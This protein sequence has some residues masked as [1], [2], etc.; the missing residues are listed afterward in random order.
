MKKRLL[1]GLA[2]GAAA[3]LGLGACASTPAEP[4]PTTTDGAANA[5]QT[6]LT[7]GVFNGWP[8]GEA[9]SY[10]WKIVLEEQGYDVTLEYA[11]AG[12]V[13]LGLS[14]GDYDVAL[15]GWFPLTHQHYLE[16]YPDIV[17]L[18][19]WNDDAVLTIHGGT[20]RT[21]RI[22]VREHRPH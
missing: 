21:D 2:I 4:E 7:I 11:D 16:E 12:T 3:A 14:E 22:A 18:G 1:A 20:S 9:A 13:F 8:E 17:D 6:A 15:D 10:L 5:D 19:A